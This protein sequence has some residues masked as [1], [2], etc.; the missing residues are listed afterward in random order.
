MHFLSSKKTAAI[1]FKRVRVGLLACDPCGSEQPCRLNMGAGQTTDRGWLSRFHAGDRDVIEGCYREHLRSVEA[2]V[3]HVLRGADKETVVHD[4]FLQLIERPDVR[5]SFQGGNF[6]GWLTTV[7]H[8][9]A[10]DYWRR[11]RR[12]RPWQEEPREEGW[13]DPARNIE[14]GAEARLFAERYLRDRLPPAWLSVFVVRFL[15]GLDQRTAAHRLGI[16]RTTLAYREL[17]VRRILRNY[18]RERS[19]A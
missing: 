1:R 16:S 11:H 6:R 13:H 18:L 9:V 4:V 3:G 19:R 15:G 5:R 2:A 14:R 12:E 7:S 10:V 8:H 17:R